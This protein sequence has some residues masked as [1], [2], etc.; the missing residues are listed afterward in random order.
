[1]LPIFRE[2]LLQAGAMAASRSSLETVLRK[3][4]GGE[5]PVLMVVRHAL[6]DDDSPVLEIGF[7]P[8]TTHIGSNKMWTEH[9][10][11][12]FIFSQTKQFA[13]QKNPTDS[14]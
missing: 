1:M 8:P 14:I 12:F 13:T 6:D 10:S 2:F 4:G 7:D 9:A 3:P 11:I 5:A